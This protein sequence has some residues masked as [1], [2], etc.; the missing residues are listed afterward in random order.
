MTPKLAVAV[1]LAQLVARASQSKLSRK[2]WSLVVP[3]CIN[4]LQMT[5]AEWQME[6]L[7]TSYERA[8]S[9]KMIKMAGWDLAPNAEHQ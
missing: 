4:E 3:Q 6:F 1:N 8:Q 2:N 7:T 9:H 5:V